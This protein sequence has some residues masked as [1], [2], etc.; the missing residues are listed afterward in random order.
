MAML[1]AHLVGLPLPIVTAMS[2]V[3]LGATITTL[4]RLQ[5]KASSPRALLAAHFFVY[6]SLYLL[7]VGAICDASLRGPQRGLSPSQWIDLGLSA[8][9]MSIVARMCLAHYRG[10][11]DVPAR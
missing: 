7:F 2:L 3:A 5:K 8:F 9:V 10:G 6:A 4:A 1:V 11:E